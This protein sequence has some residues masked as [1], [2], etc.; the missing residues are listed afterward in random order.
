MHTPFTPALTRF[1]LALAAA[2]T[3]G[4][5][6]AEVTFYENPRFEGRSFSTARQVNNLE[7]YGFSDRASSAVVL[8]QA[9]EACQD[10][11]FG[12][13]CVVLRPGR[14]PS[15]AAMGLNDRVSSARKVKANVRIADERYAPDP[16]PVY[17]NRR[18]PGE[19]LFQAQITSVR[20][21]V[22][23]PEQ[24]CWVERGDA[25]NNSSGVGGAVAG[26]LLGGILGHQIGGGSGKDLAT[27]G[28]AVAGAL[29]GARVTRNADGS[30]ADIERCETVASPYP[31]QYWDVSYTF[32]GR[33]HRVQM[34]A[35][36]GRSTLT[37]NAAGEP[38]A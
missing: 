3:V 35:P 26:A 11:R 38:R 8:G 7:R 23:T 4:H 36:P 6:M 27:A 10:V 9:W 2:A 31:P 18:R 12:G 14:Y 19:R 29:V 5:A 25:S 30:T 34:V 33:D 37:V 22:G 1:A 24:R 21:V 28:G 32:R 13:R 16:E 20:A 17:D 15:L